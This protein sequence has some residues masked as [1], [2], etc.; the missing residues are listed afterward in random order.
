LLDI[1]VAKKLANGFEV[2]SLSSNASS[3][4]CARGSYSPCPKKIYFSGNL[5]TKQSYTINKIT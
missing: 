5:F 2:L 3:L 1:P 4:G